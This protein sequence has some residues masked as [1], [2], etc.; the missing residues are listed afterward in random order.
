[1]NTIKSLFFTLLLTTSYALSALSI[2]DSRHLWGRTGFG[3]VTHFSDK[4]KSQ[5]K[6]QAIRSIL[7]QPKSKIRRITFNDS[8]YIAQK[9]KQRSKNQKREFRKTTQKKD[10]KR[11]SAWWHKQ[12]ITT[13]NPL[14]E[15][16]TVFWHRHFTSDL[17]KAS[18]PIMHNQNLLF[19]Q[20]ALG[21]F[22]DLLKATLRNPAIHLYLDNQKNTSRKP[23]ENLARELLELYTMGEGMGYTENDIKEMARALTGYRAKNS[24]SSM[25]LISRR[26]DSGM[27]TIFNQSGFYGLDSAID[28][29]LKQPQTSK[30]ITKKIL[31]EFLTDTPSQSQ[32]NY[33]SSI[34]TS[35]NYNIKP[36]LSAIFNSKDFWNHQATLVKSPYD[37]FKS[38]FSLLPTK[39]A[40]NKRVIQSISKSGQKLFYP[41]DVKG[42]RTGQS[43]LSSD[44]ILER[45]KMI[46]VITKPLKGE[47]LSKK[48]LSYAINDPEYSP[49]K[50]KWAIRGALKHDN[51]NFK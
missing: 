34:F 10:R 15:K 17:K 3:E 4:F 31:Q 50:N 51:F 35:N 39:I 41:P 43:W 29:I 6:S 16:M 8:E 42:W 45:M 36:L 48:S 30:H 13:S 28:L 9:T 38:S 11:L 12:I 14:E 25:S 21:N 2:D 22:A 18:P 5:S 7:N 1:M 47:S 24:L 32:I 20:H 26:H 23:N 33:Y 37:L 49:R 27:K 19:R 46:N 44:L 40:S